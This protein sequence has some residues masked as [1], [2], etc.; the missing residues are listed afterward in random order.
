[1][2]LDAAR[3][4][5]ENSETTAQGAIR[6]RWRKPMPGGNRQ[7][8]YVIQPATHQPGLHDVSGELALIWTL[9]LVL[10]PGSGLIQRTGYSLGTKLAFTTIPTP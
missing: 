1:M 7:S 3:R 5:Y 8:L 4:V 9:S 6:E 10:K 2:G